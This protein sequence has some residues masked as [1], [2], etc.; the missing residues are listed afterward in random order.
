VGIRETL[1]EN[2]RLTT[3][4]TIGIIV[5]ILGLIIYQLIGSGSPR[6]DGAGDV[7]TVY[8]SDDDGKN[9]FPEDRNK[10]PPFD[11]GGKEAVRAHVIKCDGKTF[12][13][14]LERYT[15][16]AKKQ[17]EA[18]LAKGMSGDPTATES[19]MSNGVEYKKP[20]EKTWVKRNDPKYLDVVKPP[21][22]DLENMEEL[23]PD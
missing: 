15:P 16:E 9:Y 12:V 23:V 22:K 2:P 14:Y 5:V 21:C 20:G 13:S 1:N 18:I 19:I 17:L 7:T 6:G 11:R 10:L 8:F 3:G 4:I